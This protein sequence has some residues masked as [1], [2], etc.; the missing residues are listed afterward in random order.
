[1]NEHKW[2]RHLDEKERR[3]WQNPEVILEEAGV[4]PGI[5]FMDIG[6]GQ[7]FFAIPAARLIGPTGKV[8]GLDIDDTGIK[9][10]WEKAAAEGL[11]NLELVSGA[12]EDALICSGCAD[13]I[14]LGTVLHDFKN[15]SK[16][17]ENAR[18]MIKRGGRLV[19]LDWKKENMSLGPPQAIR[20]DEATASRLI[21]SSGFEIESVKNSG[22]YHYLITARPD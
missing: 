3:N 11:T 9:Q 13:I 17:L 21:T 2:L 12:A 14:F 15:P 1:M 7:G 22:Q 8:Y 6:C 19:N 10:L 16:V 4:K 5:T 20:F 18:K